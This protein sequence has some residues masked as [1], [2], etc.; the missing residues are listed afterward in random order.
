MSL[1]QAYKNHQHGDILS[2]I[3]LQKPY[4]PIIKP[5]QE[6]V[7]VNRKIKQ[8]LKLIKPPPKPLLELLEPDESKYWWTKSQ[9]SEMGPIANKY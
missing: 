4:K 2:H 6:L 5:L 7:E 8:S 1:K 3:E 9:R